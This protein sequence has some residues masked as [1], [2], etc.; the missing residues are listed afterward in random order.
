MNKCHV[1]VAGSNGA[2]NRSKLQQRKKGTNAGWHGVHLA[3]TWQAF[4]FFR[5]VLLFVPK[6]W[7]VPAG[8]PPVITVIPSLQHGSPEICYTSGHRLRFRK[9]FMSMICRRRGSE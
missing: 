2:A 7:L 1:D 5:R 9:R 6:P 4:F 8:R 3:V